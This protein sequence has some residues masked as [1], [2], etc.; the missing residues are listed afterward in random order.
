LD[1]GTIKRNKNAKVYAFTKN[2]IGIKDISVTKQP[3]GTVAFNLS[4]INKS[5]IQAKSGSVFLR[6]CETCEFAEE[7]KRFRRPTGAEAY[8]REMHFDSMMAKTGFAIPLR[9]KVPAGVHRIEIAVTVRCENCVVR[10]SELLHVN[11]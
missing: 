7:P 3:D 9:V 10:Q 11:W 8:D 5:A 1:S 4:V 6:I 2:D